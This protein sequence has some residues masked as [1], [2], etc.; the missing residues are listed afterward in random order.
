M[1]EII[2]GWSEFKTIVSDRKLR[3]QFYKIVESGLD[4]YSIF[5]ADNFVVFKTKLNLG[6][7]E[8]SD[9]E[10]NY[11]QIW[12]KQLTFV[13][14]TGIQQFISSS[15][16]EG[17]TTFFSGIDDNGIEMLFNVTNQDSFLEKD[18]IFD[19]DIYIKDGTISYQDAPFGASFDAEAV[20]PEA[21]IVARFCHKVPIFGTGQF[22]LNSE[23]KSFLPQGLILRIR[24]NNAPTPAAFKAVGS[25]EG[26]RHNTV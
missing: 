22:Q 2:L 15:R 17:T 25:L 6:G 9:F 21:G 24:I 23:D 20:H 4:F 14:P 3:P 7:D 10:S 11:Q 16:P 19:E 13:D 5:T 1:Q 18:L 26:F 12:N 8:A